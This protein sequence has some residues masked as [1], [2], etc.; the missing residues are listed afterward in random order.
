MTDRHEKLQPTAMPQVDASFVDSGIEQYW[1]YEEED[2]TKR[3]PNGVK[4]W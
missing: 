1:I 2:G 3:Y 4:V